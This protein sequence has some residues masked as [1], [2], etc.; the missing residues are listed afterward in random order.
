MRWTGLVVG[1]NH[2]G[3]VLVAE[4]CQRRGIALD[5]AS[6]NA[7]AKVLDRVGFGSGLMRA[8]VSGKIIGRK[9]LITEVHQVSFTPMT[10]GAV[11]D[12]M[13]KLGF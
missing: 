7:L 6:D 5:W 2:H 8:D 9:L 13:R 10:Y 3:Y 1:T 11:V 12:Y 4:E